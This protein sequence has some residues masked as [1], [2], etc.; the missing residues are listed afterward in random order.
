MAFLTIGGVTIPV[1]RNSTPRRAPDGQGKYRWEVPSAPVTSATLASLEALIGTPSGAESD[2]AWDG[3]LLTDR[4]VVECAGDAMVAGATDCEV[5]ITSADYRS[6][7]ETAGDVP[8][9]RW[10]LSLTLREA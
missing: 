6:W 10:V 8:C 9:F 1:P 7:K 5:T 4:P 2:R 3:T